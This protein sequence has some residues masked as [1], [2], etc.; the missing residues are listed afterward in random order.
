MKFMVLTKGRPPT[1]SRCFHLESRLNLF[2]FLNLIIGNTVL[3]G[4]M[5]IDSQEMLKVL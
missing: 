3:K 2:L 4:G 5:R 1:P